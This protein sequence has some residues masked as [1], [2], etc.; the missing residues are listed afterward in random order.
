MGDVIQFP[1]PELPLGL[2]SKKQPIPVAPA[3]PTPAV[4]A[5]NP[6][7]RPARSASC[8]ACGQ[9]R[10]ANGSRYCTHCTSAGLDSP[11]INCRHEDC[12]TVAKRQFV[13]QQWFWC[14]KHHPGRLQS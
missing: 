4:Q 6:Y 5:P 14:P 11:I 10:R 12:T 13:G 1:S 9:H 3:V 7:V 2:K 8:F